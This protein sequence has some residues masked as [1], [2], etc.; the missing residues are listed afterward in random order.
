MTLISIRPLFSLTATLFLLSGFGP[1]TMAAEEQE[2]PSPK[3]LLEKTVTLPSKDVKVL[4]KH[5][6]FP[7]GFK[8]PEH[9]HDGPGPRYVIK[10]TVKIMEGGETHTYQAGE[11][12]WESGL[13]MTAENIGTGEAEIVIFELAPTE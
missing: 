3:P 11:V 10:G 9:T 1:L 4:V 13:P 7:E 2:K 8:T 5:M 6:R 12:F